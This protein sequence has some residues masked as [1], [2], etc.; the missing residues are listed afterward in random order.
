VIDTADTDLNTK[1]SVRGVTFCLLAAVLLITLGAIIAAIIVPLWQDR[2][3]WL[4]GEFH[5]LFL[6][7]IVLAAILQQ[8][9]KNAFFGTD[10][11]QFCKFA[12]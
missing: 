3:S 2:S 10:E 8:Y 12:K 1:P 6:P 4:N 5:P 11:F 7:L 9:I